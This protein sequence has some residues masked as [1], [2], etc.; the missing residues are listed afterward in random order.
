MKKMLEFN[1]GKISLYFWVYSMNW[2]FSLIIE[3]LK[4]Y[5]FVDPYFINVFIAQL[6]QIMGGLSIYLYQY[7]AFKKNENTKYFGLELIYNKANV[8]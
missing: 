1:L 2:L 5:F 3:L 4:Y 7:K 6:A 8:K